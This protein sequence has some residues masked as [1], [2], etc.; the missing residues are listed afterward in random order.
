MLLTFF[1]ASKTSLSFSNAIILLTVSSNVCNNILSTGKQSKD[2]NS[3]KVV[4]N[5]KR[6]L[7]MGS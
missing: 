5:F 4:Q 2:F 6:T 1:I 7:I 3:G